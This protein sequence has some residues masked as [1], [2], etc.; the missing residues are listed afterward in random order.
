MP[1]KGRPSVKGVKNA[2]ATFERVAV[3]NARKLIVVQHVRQH[4]MASAVDRFFPNISQSSRKNKKRQIY[5]WVKKE[6]QLVEVVANGQGRHQKNRSV[7]TGCV[8]PTEVEE[9]LVRWV[10]DLRRGESTKGE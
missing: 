9:A 8:L 1:P 7:G 4:G 3:D 6:D 2:P 10:N 5:E